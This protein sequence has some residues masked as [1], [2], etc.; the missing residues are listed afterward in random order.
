MAAAN[1]RRCADRVLVLPHHGRAGL[2]DA[3]ARPLQPAGARPAPLY[4]W[5][6]LHLLALAMGPAGFVAVIAG[7]VTTE[8]GRQPYTVYGLLRTADSVSPLQAPAVAASLLAFIVV[9]FIVFGAGIFY[10][11][12][13]MSHPP[14]RGEAGPERGQPVRAAGI[15]PSPACR[16]PDARRAGGPDHA[17]LRSAHHLGLHHRLRGLRLC[18]DGRLR[19]RHR[20]PVPVRS[21]RARARHR[22]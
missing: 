6:W 14:H 10:I 3:G 16:K 18:R 4:D 20:H 8:V 1:G 21:R 2:G 19:S 22:R 5:R 11:L 9:Y 15:T 12:R 17:H 13:L 7:W